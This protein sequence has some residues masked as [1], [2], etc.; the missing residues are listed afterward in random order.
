V[1]AKL[2]T[3][4]L[5]GPA[6][7]AAPPAWAQRLHDDDIRKMMIEDSLARFGAQD[8]PCPYSYAW[9]GAQCADKSLYS[10]RA[11]ADL[12]CY[13]A[14]ITPHMIHEYRRQHDF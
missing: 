9:N 5:L 12:L 14:D 11:A 3:A 13:P 2:S 10:R 1:K 6:L 8:C 7:L 4:L